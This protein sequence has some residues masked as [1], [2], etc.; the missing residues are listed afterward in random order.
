MVGMWHL[1]CFLYIFRML[2]N[3]II[4]ALNLWL[5]IWHCYQDK[6]FFD[7]LAFLVQSHMYDMS[8]LLLWIACDAEVWYSPYRKWLVISS[9]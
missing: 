2:S 3:Q 1:F 9:V 8:L 5:A 7:L 6:I 4:C